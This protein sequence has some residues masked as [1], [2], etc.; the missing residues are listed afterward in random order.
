MDEPPVPEMPARADET[1]SC[2][3]CGVNWLSG[4]HTDGCK[5][6]GGGA[7]ELPCPFCLGRCGSAWKRMV[8]DSQ[9]SR[10]AHWLGGCKLPADEKKL[11]MEKRIREQTRKS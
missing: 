11:E 5:Q 3:D 8:M 2:T 6:C 10:E 7:M 1:V 9:D 4:V